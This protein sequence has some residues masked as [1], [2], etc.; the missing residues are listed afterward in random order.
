[1]SD[2]TSERIR[3]LRRALGE[4]TATFAQRLYRSG[5]TIEDWEQGRSR[6]DALVCREL[7]RIERAAV[8]RS[9]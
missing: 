9:G 1:M 2:W 5:R 3:E 7:E 6:P 4:N 8:A